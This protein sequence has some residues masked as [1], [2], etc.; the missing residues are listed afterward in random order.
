MD[1]STARQWVLCFSSS[2][3]DIKDKF[4]MALQIL[5]SAKCRQFITGETAELMVEIMLKNSVL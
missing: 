2:N 3:S 1:A 4:W 5:M